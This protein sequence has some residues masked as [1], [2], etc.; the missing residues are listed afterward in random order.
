MASER[1]FIVEDEVIVAMDIQRGLK[2]LGYSVLGIANN[3]AEALEKIDALSPDLVLMDIQIQGELDGIQTAKKLWERYRTPVVFLTAYADVATLDRAKAAESFGYILKPF[4]DREL[5]TAIEVALSKHRSVEV[6][7]RGHSEALAQSE[8][9]FKLFIDSVKDYGVFMLDPKGTVLSWNIGAERIKGYQAKE[10]VGR[11]FEIFYTREE[12]AHGRPARELK[13]ASSQGS[14]AEEGWRVRKDGSRFWASVV[15][16]ALR[17][18]DGELRGY[19]KVTRDLTTK[20]QAQDA[21]EMS[22]AR[23]AAILAGALDC[24]ISMDHEGRIIEFNPAAEN[25]FGHKRADVLGKDMAEV[26]IPPQL[27]HAHRLGLKNYLASGEGPVLGK[28]IELPALRADGTQFP[29]ELSII[30]LQLG[31][32]PVF[33]GFLREITERKR[34]EEERAKLLENETNARQRLATQ[35]RVMSILAEAGTLQDASKKILQAIAEDMGWDLGCFWLVNDEKPSSLR[36]IETW[37]SPKGNAPEFLR[38][39]ETWICPSGVGLPGR[40]L[41]DSKQVWIQDVTLDQNFPRSELAVK[42]GLHG[43]LG[44]PILSGKRVVGVVEF[45][46]RQIRAPDDE[47]LQTVATLSGQI[48]QFMDRLA[49]EEGLRK[50]VR[51]RDEFI[52]IASHELKTPITSMKLQTQNL[53]RSI[54]RAGLESVGPERVSKA[55]NV[56]THQLDR[57]TRLVEDML[58]ITKLGSGNLKIEKGVFDLGDLV[59]EV[60]ERNR[61]QLAAARIEPSLELTH[62]LNGRWDRFRLDQ[63]ITNLISN[64]IKYGAGKPVQIKVWKKDDQALISVRDHGIGIPK[65]AQ[66]RIFN[67]FE[68]AVAVTDISGLGLGLYIVSEILKAHGGAIRVESE[69]GKGAEF[70]IQLPLGI[71]AA[72][73]GGVAEHA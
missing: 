53:A 24:I 65:E 31:S 67:R 70:V 2:R 41:Q 69:P 21:L 33:T 20:K 27:R 37:H 30:P 59:R 62:G 17:D 4:E 10:V 15:I 52:S 60:V 68:R 3:C 1:I 58:D 32:H 6:E 38:A 43:A 11:N 22:E 42:V 55:L 26:I 46:S 12:V 40:I 8:E 36:A 45:F 9:Q 64:A 18:R 44:F 61:E 51:I 63:V 23:K 54:A 66:G 50:A 14:Y 47:L 56:S 16:T 25:T 39:M 34:I 48:G 57:L 28:R 49:A 35:Y 71:S 72:E 29:I 5:H 13:I 73:S 7:H 19:G